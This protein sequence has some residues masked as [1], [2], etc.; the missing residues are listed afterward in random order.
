MVGKEG[1]K[2]RPVKTTKSRTKKKEENR[3]G[4]KE[5]GGVTKRKEK[6]GR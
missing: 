6:G 1:T 2:K 4:G 3:G 5:L